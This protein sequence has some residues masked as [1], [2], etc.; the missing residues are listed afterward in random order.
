MQFDSWQDF[1]HMGG[2]AMYVW[3][4]FGATFVGML[5]L[6]VHS[7]LAHKLLVRHAGEEFE[8]RARVKR[9]RDAEKSRRHEELL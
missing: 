1:W 8:R 5:G 3:L 2:Y 9:A 4:S 6:V 7:N